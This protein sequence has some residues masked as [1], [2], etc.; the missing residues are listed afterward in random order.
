M[1][2]GCNGALESWSSAHPALA[3]AFRD[4]IKSRGILTAAGLG[5]FEA[6]GFRIGHMGDIRATDIDRTLGAVRAALEAAVV[7]G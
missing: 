1:Q 6:T 4:S 5:P 7:S 3:K 2:V